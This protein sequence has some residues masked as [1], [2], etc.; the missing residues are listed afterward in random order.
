MRR[1]RRPA[2]DEGRR[3]HPDQSRST[4]RFGAIRGDCVA[5]TG[6]T[7]NGAVR[8]F[9]RVSRRAEALRLRRRRR[10]RLHAPRLPRRSRKHAD[11]H[12]LHAGARCLR[13]GRRRDHRPGDPYKLYGYE[14]MK[15]I[16]D[17]L[18]AAGREPAGAA[19]LAA[20]RRP[21]PRERARHL[22]LR[23]QRRH[24]HRASTAST[25]SA[26]KA[27]VWE[28]A[29]HGRL[30]S[31]MPSSVRVPTRS[32][33]QHVAPV[34]RRAARAAGV[35]AQPHGREH[36]RRRARTRPRPARRERLV[37]ARRTP[38][39]AGA[40]RQRA[41]IRSQLRRRVGQRG[42]ALVPVDR[43]RLSGSTSD[44]HSSS[45]PW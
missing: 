45:S 25:A 38:P 21:E 22:R 15:L 7:A 41:R 9:N 44:R 36:R 6:I 27:L 35:A 34:A 16:L 24:D 14:A 32:V 39:A 18:N 3:H 42:A 23:R 10:V 40:Q 4:R 26:R 17:G 33:A 1:D 31:A 37:G 43:R 28:G 12:R 30:S 5:Y 2:R 8:M 13:P 20:H 11:G 19:R 29:D